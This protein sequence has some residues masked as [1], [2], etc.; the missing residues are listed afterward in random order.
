[1]F[2]ICLKCLLIC[3]GPPHGAA[4]NHANYNVSVLLHSLRNNGKNRKIPRQSVTPPSQRPAPRAATPTQTHSHRC[5]LT[6]RCPERP[7]NTA[8][9][10]NPTHAA[11]TPSSRD[12]HQ[13]PPTIKNRRGDA[14][15]PQNN[16]APPPTSPTPEA[17]SAP[18]N[19]LYYQR[20]AFL[21]GRPHCRSEGPSTSIILYFCVSTDIFL[22]FVHAARRCSY[23]C[24]N[25][26]SLNARDTFWCII[27][28]PP[29][30]S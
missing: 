13:R 9:H 10:K 8:P 3:G 21:T 14:H 17:K 15:L 30:C 18:N 5:L 29:T 26:Y 1:V 20:V 25:F 2:R 16:A 24:L 19:Q 12:A 4:K 11:P 23:I 6:H 7:C 22:S 28:W 27:C